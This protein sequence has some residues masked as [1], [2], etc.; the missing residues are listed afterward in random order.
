[1]YP[2]RHVYGHTSREE[3]MDDSFWYFV[4]YTSIWQIFSY[5]NVES[6]VGK[7]IRSMYFPTQTET[8]D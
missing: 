6:H 4:I 3:Y 8:L 1:M 5:S 7:A 2:K